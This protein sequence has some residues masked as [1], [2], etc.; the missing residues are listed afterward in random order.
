MSELSAL[1]GK[2]PYEERDDRLFLG[3]MNRVTLHHLKGC[4]EY[5]RVWEGWR[6]AES[7]ADLPFLHV[8]LFKR[9]LF[10]TVSAGIE[11][12]RFLQSSSTSGS[13]P[14]QVLLD[15]RSSEWQSQSSTAILKDFLSIASCPLLVLDNPK[16]LRQRHLSARTA[17]ALA[18]CPLATDMRF[19]LNASDSIRWDVVDEAAR[20][21]DSLLVYGFTWAFW[22]TWVTELARTAPAEVRARL[23]S[24]YIAFV[25]SGGWKK[26]AA[27]QVDRKAF[28]SALLETS[29]PGSQ[30]LDFYGLVEQTGVVYPLCDFNFRHVP[31]WADVLV[32]DPFTLTP[33]VGEVG[34]LQL[35]NPLPLG[36]PYHSVLTEDLGRIEPGA[37]SCGRSG[38]RFEVLGRI[39]KA[40][41][42]GCANV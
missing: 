10:K 27:L 4:P 16:N 24:K 7:V 11:H 38:T 25:H 42:R 19:V 29:G 22:T 1:L 18:L 12:G 2:F 40:E 28:D 20:S 35:L 32:R 31:V 3:E 33:L 37:C 23:A 8:D 6:K 26:L 14:S 36:A 39:P 41:L 17:A 5:S 15:R 34:Q 21:A 13:Q 30:V 9:V